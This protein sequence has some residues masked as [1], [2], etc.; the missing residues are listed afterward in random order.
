YN[1][2]SGG[3]L[4]PVLETLEGIVAKGKWLEVTTLLIPE[5][6]DSTEELKAL[7]KWLAGLSVDIPWH[8]SRFSPRYKQMDR[9]ATP[10][11]VMEKARDIGRE[12]GLRY[13]YIGNACGPGYGDTVC[14]S[15]GQVLIRRSGFWVDEYLL[16]PQGQCPG[17]GTRLA[18]RWRAK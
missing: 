10:A 15:C 2:I 12:S 9:P 8:I 5:L 16:D 3:S 13:V 7:T 11:S 14:P 6:N 1:K 17:C 18:G 4:R